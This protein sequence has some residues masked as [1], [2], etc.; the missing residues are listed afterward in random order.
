MS[1]S[2]TCKTSRNPESD[3]DRYYVW[4]SGTT[5][6][7]LRRRVDESAYTTLVKTDVDSDVLR[8]YLLALLEA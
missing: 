5:L 3:S 1:S 2:P 6:A 7:V 8:Q 4:I